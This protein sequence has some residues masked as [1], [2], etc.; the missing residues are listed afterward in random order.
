MGMNNTPWSRRALLRGI[1]GAAGLGTLGTLAAV[2][3]QALAA[4]GDRKFLFFF[5]SGGWDATPL[6]PKFAED[7]ASPLDTSS[8][9]TDMD[10]DTVLG[11]A[12]NLSWSSGPDRPAMDRFFTR[13]GGRTSLIRGVNVHSAGHESG[14]KWMMTGTTALSLIH[15]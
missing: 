2:Q 9:A 13:W 8:G 15:I 14:M 7:G 1:A 12:G 4:S 3:E 11:Q 5:A 10:P 6:D